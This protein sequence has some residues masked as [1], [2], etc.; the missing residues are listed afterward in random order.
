MPSPFS[1]TKEYKFADGEKIV[2]VRKW[3]TAKLLRFAEDLSRFAS[4]FQTVGD[5]PDEIGFR[6]DVTGL[7]EAISSAPEVVSRLIEAS[8]SHG[9]EEGEDPLEWDIEDVIGISQCIFELNS[10]S[11]LKKRAKG[12]FQAIMPDGLSAEVSLSPGQS[13]GSQMPAGNKSASSPQEG[14]PSPGSVTKTTALRS[15]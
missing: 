12:L 5:N 3:S 4:C 11:L 8:I 2:T 1:R 15:K 9:L 13:N 7:V 10:T 6:F 14:N